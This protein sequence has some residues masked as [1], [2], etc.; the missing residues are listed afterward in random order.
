MRRERKCCGI[1]LSSFLENKWRQRIR[2]ALKWAKWAMIVTN[3]LNLAVAATILALYLRTDT[4][5]FDVNDADFTIYKNSRFAACSNWTPPEPVNCTL[6]MTD[7]GPEGR[8]HSK[9]LSQKGRRYLY[10]PRL[11]NWRNGPENSDTSPRPRI[12][13]CNLSSCLRGFKVV[14]STPLHSAY[15]S[16]LITLWFYCLTTTLLALK[17]LCDVLLEDKHYN[18]ECGGLSTLDYVFSVANLG[19]FGLWM[20]SFGRLMVDPRNATPVSLLAWLAPLRQAIALYFH[21]F[22]CVLHVRR[23]LR[24]TLTWSFIAIASFQLIATLVS[25]KIK[26]YDHSGQ[27]PGY[28]FSARYQCL[29]SKIQGA[30]G[31]SSCT[32]AQ[33]CSKGWLFS[34]PG[35]KFDAGY[36]SFDGFLARFKISY[37]ATFF[38]FV[39][40]STFSGV[41]AMFF[42]KY[43]FSPTPARTPH[44]ERQRRLDKKARKI[45]PTFPFLLLQFLIILYGPF[46]LYI[47][48]KQ[49]TDTRDA[50][51]AYDVECR[52]VHVGL[53]PWRG[54][55]D[56]RDGTL[57]VRVARMLLNA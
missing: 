3:V 15:S 49:T 35:W 30:P 28:D 27:A 38:F 48:I 6:V 7:L 20:Y 57:A 56:V 13:W 31:F 36:R 21:P 50:P 52:A 12:D 11:E 16:P 8:S 55:L 2:T 23:S 24:R 4:T 19:A 46:L 25:L 32:P 14:P 37:L 22:H 33:I 26:W 17:W 9:E 18:K 53:S 41:S 42:R 29:E 51:V 39:L 34:Y 40:T 1:P 45:F 54:Y 10:T 5:G 43:W 47:Y 44:R